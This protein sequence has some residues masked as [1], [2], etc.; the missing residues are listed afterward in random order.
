LFANRRLI[1]Y[2]AAMSMSNPGLGIRFAFGLTIIATVVGAFFPESRLWAI[3]QL[4]YLPHWAIAV[5]PIGI[6]ALGL[7]AASF[8]NR[9]GGL[10][11]TRMFPAVVSGFV[12]FAVAAFVL[13]HTRTHF[14]GDGYTSISLLASDNPLIK[15][16]NFGGEIVP[17]WL[18]QVIGN[19]TEAAVEQAYQFVSYG[20]GVLFIIM[21]AWSARRL[22]S[23]PVDALLF[24]LVLCTGG[25][26]LLFFGYVENYALFVVSVGAYCLVG[27]RIADGQVSRCWLLPAQAMCLFFHVFGVLLIPATV[28]VLIADTKPG[29]RWARLTRSI[30]AG[31]LAGAALVVLILAV[32]AYRASY[33]F[34]FAL[35]PPLPGKFAI[36][37]YWLFSAAHLLD[38]GNLLIIMWPGLLV[39]LTA[40]ALKDGRTVSSRRTHFLLL[41]TS[42]TL[43]AVF[44]I[45]PKIGMPR[46]WDLFSFAGLPLGMLLFDR[47]SA[48]NTT[49][50]RTATVLVVAAGFLLLVI[51]VVVLATPEAALRQNHAYAYLDPVKNHNSWPILIAYYEKAGD[52]VSARTS[53][54]ERT[55]LLP[56]ETWMTAARQAMK[57]GDHHSAL[58]LSLRAAPRY[59]GVG[60]FHA[61]YGSALLNLGRADEA[62][63]ELRIA[64]ALNPYNPIVLANLGIIYLNRGDAE[65]AERY[66]RQT[67]DREPNSRLATYGLTAISSRNGNLATLPDL[68]ERGATIENMRLDFY[69]MIAGAA[70][71][72]K[73]YALAARALGLGRKRGLSDAEVKN[74]L[75]ANPALAPYL[76]TE[77][78]KESPS[79]PT[80]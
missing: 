10:I 57:D 51:R 40:M 48:S 42:L 80:L 33:G 60:S 15:W 27:L 22:Y 14:L 76:R 7:S 24:V 29:R 13:M 31:S 38:F 5:F 79:T 45:D 35:V 37:N 4:G 11:T 3:N 58:R 52:P 72:G 65:T 1:I 77:L 12:V 46:D 8:F 68:L 70:L 30:R 25:H 23:G 54:Q 6:A 66:W 67:L 18:A 63:E 28:F 47:L 2:I 78:G 26:M 17:Y 56:E 34:R 39:A 41:V 64:Q 36:E 53:H 20:A 61:N 75:T 32:A 55:E 50:R 19:G 71:R 62:Y 16:R 21:A 74:L 44:L 69:E 49:I 9:H 43:G 73:D 59:H